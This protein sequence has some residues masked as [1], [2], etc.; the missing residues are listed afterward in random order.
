MH[1]K[2]FMTRLRLTVLLA[3]LAVIPALQAGP[4]SPS[5]DAA[6]YP[7]GFVSATNG[8]DAGNDCADQF[9]PCA[10]IQHAIDEAVPG[11]F[12]AV[13]PI[14]VVPGIY[15]EQL[16]VD[17][18]VSLVGP[19]SQREGRGP[20]AVIDGG[21]GTAIAPEARDIEIKGFTI[22]TDAAGT[23]IRTVG[24]DVDR[25]TIST[26][27]IE[28]GASG[29]WLGAGGDETRV[30]LN[31]IQGDAYGIHLGATRYT[32]LKLWYNQLT[33]PA[34]S[35]GVFAGTDTEL[36]DFELEGNEFATASLGASIKNGWV[37]ANKVKPPAGGVGLRAN[38]TESYV[39]ENSFRGEGAAS[40]LRLLGSH[41]G[42]DPTNHV[43]VSDNDFSG[44]VPYAL[45][46]GPKVNAISITASTF[47]NSYDGIVTDDS[48]PWD[49]PDSIEIWGNRLVG[50]AHLGV[51]NRV[52]G[53]IDARNNWWGC[54]GGPGAVG[55]DNVSSGVDTSP[56]VVLT[57]EASEDAEKAWTAPV[58]TLNPGEKAVV[59]AYLKNGNGSEALNVPTEGRTVSFSSP[60]GVL[61]PTSAT[62]QNARAV[63]WFGAGSQ[64]GPAGIMVT[65][66]NQQVGFPLTI[67][68]PSLTTPSLP[69]PS[70]TKKQPQIRILGGTLSLS[71]RKA[72]IG[73]ISCAQSE[74]HV[75]QK[76]ARAKV[77]RNWF[78]VKLKVPTD[79]AAE[80]SRQIRAM[81]PERALRQL[82]RHGT[83]VLAVT[84]KMTDAS[85]S[86]ASM[87][88]KVK[89]AWAPHS[90]ESEAV[91]PPGS[92]KRVTVPG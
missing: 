46:L 68:G 47:P 27:I 48:S 19:N 50:I 24:A 70:S 63:S 51:Y 10:T 71:R 64:G 88:Q 36:D 49:V 77:G 54:N 16:T 25:L 15:A 61:S 65:M 72:V 29:V 40:C 85:N 11:P 12:G 33:G 78:S 91:H 62:W 34:G 84:M 28:G 90:E 14:Y 23:P 52:G 37:L 57:A 43:I 44:C 73:T 67:T 4:A 56:N 13:P 2:G 76:S 17:K 80:S 18:P 69:T 82:A 55:C 86:A 39:R 21:V 31:Q 20:E 59:L 60:S 66:D 3:A 38:L 92:Q 75:N 81:M 26:N 1:R 42:L 41:D 8:S 79:L 83:G 89:I 6:A 74:C 45:E 58:S 30:L 32:K 35:Y 5:A 22:S 9:A 87:N 7:W 53:Q